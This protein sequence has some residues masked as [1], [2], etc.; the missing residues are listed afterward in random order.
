MRKV[1]I[2]TAAIL[3]AVVFFLLATMPSRPR[4]SSGDPEPELARRLVSGAYH[5]HTTRSDGRGTRADVAAAAARANLQFVIFTDHGD[6]TARGEPPEY[7]DGVLCV[8]GVE[9]STNGGHYVA[10]DMPPAPYPLGGE[11]DTVVEDVRRLGGFGVAAHPGSA[12]DGLRWTDWSL[13]VDAME[14][15]NADSEWRDETLS[16]LVRL[17]FD[18]FLR[19]AGALATML[20][21]PVDVLGRLDA[22]AASRTIVAL[23]AHDAH[24][25]VATR[26]EEGQRLGRLGIPS[27]EAAFRAFWITVRLTQPFQSD[28]IRDTRELFEALR[29]GRVFTSIGAIAA[30]AWMDFRASQ[31]DREAVMGAALPSGVPTVFTL[32]SPR[33]AGA[34]NV[35]VCNGTDVDAAETDL[36][37]EFTGEGACRAEI[38]VPGAPGTPPVPWILGNPIYLRGPEE[39]PTPPAPEIAETVVSLDAAGLVVEKDAASNATATAS[40]GGTVLAFR[41]ADGGRASQYVALA[42]ALKAPREP[43][44]RIVLTARASRPLRLSVQLRFDDRGGARWGASVYVPSEATRLTIPLSRFRSFDGQTTPPDWAGATGILLVV[45]LTNADPGFDGRLEVSDIVLARGRL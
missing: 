32:R 11:P 39:L 31:P 26:L 15:M 13:P 12:K 21:R 41:L 28:P 1:L 42:S 37:S 20:D 8:D 14:W 24:G 35:L 9:I 6:G 34:T 16:G 36:E 38:R 25:G 4:V 22:F 10:L 44:D 19:P 7:L 29:A 5:V 27:Y 17:P 30:P 23:A 2:A 18:Y 43:F 40:G 45:D 33:V 3:A